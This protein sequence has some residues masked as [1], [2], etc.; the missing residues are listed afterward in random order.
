MPD[1]GLQVRIVEDDFTPYAWRLRQTLTSG[2]SKVLQAV[3]V[4]VVSITRQA[5][6]DASLRAAPWAP[7]R[8]GSPATLI[9]SGMLR[10][11][12]RIANISGTSVTVGSD[13]IYAAVQQLGATITPK[14]KRTLAFKIGGVSVFARK[15]TI[16][17]RPFLPVD[18]SGDF[19]PTA[20]QRVIAVLNQAIA[21]Y[22]T[23]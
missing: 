18:A 14:S 10:A 17:P 19:T 1:S 16:P 13:R 6:T 12:I 8:D 20:Q 5:F 11:S 7:K 4:E 3:G 21:A 9:Q 23:A 2:L 22:T 15:V